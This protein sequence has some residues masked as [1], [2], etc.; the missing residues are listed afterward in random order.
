MQ[1]VGGHGLVSVRFVAVLITLFLLKTFYY[2][3]IL[4]CTLSFLHYTIYVVQYEMRIH[5]IIV[6]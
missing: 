2:L 6:T 1:C 4:V 3:Y 5:M